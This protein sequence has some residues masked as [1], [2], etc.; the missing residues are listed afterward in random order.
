MLSASRPRGFSL[1]ELMVASAISLIALAAAVS[2]YGTSARHAGLQLQ[3]THLHQQLQTLLFLI[4]RDLRRA[5]Y[6]RFDAT[7]ASPADNPFQ[8]GGNR[9]RVAALAGEAP[10]SCLLL[11]YDLDGD[12]HVGVGACDG[13]CAAPRDDDNVEQFGYRL[14]AGGL[15]ARY[16]GRGLDCDSGHW[17]RLNDPDLVIA[18]LRFR[19]YTHCVNLASSGAEDCVPG[20]PRLLQRSVRID[21]RAHPRA[22]PQQSLQLTRWVRVR[23]DRLVAAP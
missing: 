21:V 11:A 2:A 23:N 18:G 6:W 16:G 13:R 4:G 5:G 15:Q 7:R 22:R 10:A 12:G 9:L 20:Q 3:S 8:Q 19:L 1:V 17:Q 14:R